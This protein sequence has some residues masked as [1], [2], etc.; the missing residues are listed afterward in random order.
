[1][2]SFLFQYPI[3]FTCDVSFSTSWLLQLLKLSL[4]LM[5]LT[6]LRSTIL[7]DLSGIFIM[8]Y[9]WAMFFWG[10]KTKVKCHCHHIN[11]CTYYQYDISLMLT[12]VTWL[13][14]CVSGFPDV[15]LLFFPFHA[16]LFGGQSRCVACTWGVGSCNIPPRG[17]G[18]NIY[19][20]YLEFVSSPHLFIYTHLSMSMDSWILIL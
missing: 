5:I 16:V 9:T 20:K 18:K 12:L 4:F 6:V 14:H 19:I 7:G 8:V 3:T 1:M 15:N 11:K 13:R 10:R 2:S 17:K